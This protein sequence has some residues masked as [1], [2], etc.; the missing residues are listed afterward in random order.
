MHRQKQYDKYT[1]P[2]CNESE[3]IQSVD[4]YIGTLQMII[5][6]SEHKICQRLP[7]RNNLF[8]V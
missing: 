5:F 7:S 6:F 4:G 8:A 2:S 3:F 1:F